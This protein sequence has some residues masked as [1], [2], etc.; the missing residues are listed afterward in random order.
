VG[1]EVK[2]TLLFR[3]SERGF[4]ATE[5]HRV[6]DGKGPTITLVRADNGMMAAAY[7]DVDWGRPWGRASN[8][9]GFLASIVN[10]P[11]AIRVLEYEVFQVE[12]QTIF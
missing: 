12:I 3:A 7:N 6:C 1:I 9:Q 4:L 10:D 11:R 8:P 2:M 5:F